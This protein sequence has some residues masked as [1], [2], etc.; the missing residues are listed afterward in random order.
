MLCLSYEATLA[1]I[2]A[3]V[4]GYEDKPKLWCASLVPHIVSTEVLP[5]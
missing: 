1:T 4:K 5:I 2:D 3:A